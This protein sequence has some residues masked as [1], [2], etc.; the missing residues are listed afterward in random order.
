MSGITVKRSIGVRVIVSEEFKED[1][2]NELQEAATE[3]QRRID[4]ME[5]NSRR[6]LAD[7]Q[8]TDLSQAMQARRQIEAERQRHDALK[9][10]IQRQLQEVDKLEIGG[11][12]PRGTV[13]GVVELQQG[14]DLV[15][16]LSGSQ[17]VVKDGVIVEIRET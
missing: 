16:K 14:D 8:R 1:L 7:L 13:E 11:E 3:T 6:L 15:Q 9:Q 2:K 12:Y 5:M 4:Q 10:D 17:I